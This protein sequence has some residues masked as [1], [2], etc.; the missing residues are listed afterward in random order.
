MA[1]NLMLAIGLAGG[2]L[3]FGVS[4]AAAAPLSPANQTLTAE[5]IVEKAQYRY[6]RRWNRECRYRWGGGWRY[7]RCMARHGC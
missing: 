6:C 2:S 7:R 4:T 5:A 1:R 3:L